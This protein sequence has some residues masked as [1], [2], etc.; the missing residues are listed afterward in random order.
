MNRCLSR[1]IQKNRQKGSP[2]LQK[3]GSIG[4]EN[5]SLKVLPLAFFAFVFKITVNA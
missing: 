2:K 1:P 3:S 4:K 5:T